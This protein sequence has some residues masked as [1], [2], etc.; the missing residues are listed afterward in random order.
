MTSPVEFYENQLIE[1]RE[2]INVASAKFRLWVF[3]RLLI[4]VFIGLLVYFTWGDWRVTLASIV[5]GL[6]IFI[7][8]I[9]QFQTAKTRLNK[10]KKWE[11]I[12]MLEIASLN[13]AISNFYDGEDFKDPSHPF[14][15]DMDLFGKN[16][17]Y[18][19]FNR[20]FSQKGRMFLADVLK[21]GVSSP[22]EVN[23]LIKGL[24][25]TM[26]WNLQFRVN[27]SVNNWGEFI[28]EDLEGLKS[29]QLK[30]PSWMKTASY[31]LTAI[32]VG[33][34]LALVFSWIDGMTFSLVLLLNLF[35]A[36]LYLKDTNKITET[37]GK[38]EGKVNFLMNQMELLQKLTT[39][40]KTLQEFIERLD[41]DK[42]AH[43]ALRD[44]LKIQRRFEMRINVLI[45]ILLNGL[46]AWDFHQRIALKK[47]MN[48]NQDKIQ[49]WEEDLIKL[50]TYVSG[51]FIKF[52]Y[53][54]TIFA[55]FTSSD[56]IDVEDLRH[57]LIPKEKAV[58]NNVRFDKNRRLMI[59]TGPN[60]AGKSTYLRSVGL[61]FVLGNAGFPIVAKKAIIPP[62]K[63]YSSMRTSDDLSNESSYFHAELSRLKFILTEIEKGTKI[64]ILLDEIL[65]GT[66][67]LDK[68]QGSKQFLQKLKRLGTQGIIA[69]HDLSL[70]ELSENST[71]FY[72][73]YFDS[74][75]TNDE[76]HFDYLWREGVC[77]NMNAS[78]LLKKMGL[79]D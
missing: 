52:N 53:P 21:N 47:W 34:F 13:G 28:E 10:A 31:F 18:Q 26:A 16:S 19:F 72:N 63:L 2:E 70:C 78:F 49:N 5:G 55:T 46:F 35:F 6:V 30:N 9:S 23:E 56:E 58:A 14:A 17:I 66:N 36:M 24:S 61:L 20:T 48:Q 71:Y 57:P 42:G 74:T 22:S 65:K 25:Q 11:E 73:G 41:S 59:L 8:A 44:L 38:F 1:A 12:T 3:L 68:E 76:L 7:A 75:I 62:Y 64:F 37:I 51:A 45:G 40:N 33:A 67:S 60:M 39:D 79:T 69:T 15:Y 4:F 43:Q 50:E 54:E 27:G 32:G 77:Q 29:F